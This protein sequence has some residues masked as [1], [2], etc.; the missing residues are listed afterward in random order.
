MLIL[1]CNK[2]SPGVIVDYILLGLDGGITI[3][4]LAE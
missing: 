4:L 1:G 2:V 3:R